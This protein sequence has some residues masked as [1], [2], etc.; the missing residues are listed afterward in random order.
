MSKCL[1]KLWITGCNL[2]KG[3]LIITV[4]TTLFGNAALLGSKQGLK[5]MVVW[6]TF[7]LV[8]RCLSEHFHAIGQKKTHS[9]VSHSPKGIFTCVLSGPLLR[10]YSPESNCSLYTVHH[11]NT[12]AYFSMQWLWYRLSTYYL[13]CGPLSCF[14]T[15]DVHLY[16]TFPAVMLPS[17]RCMSNKSGMT[18]FCMSLALGAAGESHRECTLSVQS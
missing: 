14:F 8:L 10:L 5:L 9:S 3:S 12:H 17:H 15:L 18:I 7:S 1:R 13:L 16:H 11:A 6:L 4:R 2:E